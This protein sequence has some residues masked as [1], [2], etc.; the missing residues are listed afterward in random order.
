MLYGASH[1]AG[2]T[3]CVLSVIIAVFAVACE[4]MKLFVS[5][6]MD[7]GPLN[8]ATMR[9]PGLLALYSVLVQ[10]LI[11]RVRQTTHALTHT[12]HAHCRQL[13]SVRSLGIGSRGAQLMLRQ[14]PTCQARQA[15][16]MYLA[17][18]SAVANEC[19]RWPTSS[20]LETF[21]WAWCAR[22][23]ALGR[24]P[25]MRSVSWLV[26]CCLLMFVQAE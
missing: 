9:R 2:F 19:D 6:Q 11:A 16:T 10:L 18:F 15:T 13:R 24:L 20:R 25:S 3:V 12:K 21:G 26:S 7:S 22:L 5:T 8:E 14:P 1:V 23:T 17:S 4:L